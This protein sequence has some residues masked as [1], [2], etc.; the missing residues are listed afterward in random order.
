MLDPFDLRERALKLVP[1]A[2]INTV[3]LEPKPGEV[4]ALDL[5]PRINSAT[6]E[7]YQLGF[8]TLKLNPYT[9]VEVESSR[10][11]TPPEQKGYFPLT[12]KNFLGFVLAL[13]YQLALDETGGLV[14]GIVALVWTMDCFVGFYLTLPKGKSKHPA[15]AGQQAS[16]AKPPSFW[17]RWKPAWLIKWPA[18][19]MR[20]NF[21]FHRAFGLWTWII[22]FIFAWSSV[23]F[24]LPQVY[25]PVMGLLFN[26]PPEQSPLPELPVPRPDPAIDFHAAHAIGKRLMAEQAKLHGFTVKREGTLAYDETTGLFV[27]SV[28]SDRD[29]CEDDGSSILCYEYGTSL[30]FDASTG[31]LQRREPLSTGE[32]SETSVSSWFWYL[33][34]AAIW[35]LPYRLFVCFMGLVITMLSVTGVYIWYKK[36]S[37]ARL[38]RKMSKYQGIVT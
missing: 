6:V 1:Q 13:H 36:H 2:R 12:R 7:P 26:H 11:A 31:K 34:R 30:T 37:A 21:D 10:N 35:G 33:H 17:Q 18:S 3:L 20:V 27:Y 16:V 23:M 32:Y 8:D 5:Q 4:Y 9:G 15:T 19:A 22:L 29:L 14:F 25:N 38:K 24:N 28:K